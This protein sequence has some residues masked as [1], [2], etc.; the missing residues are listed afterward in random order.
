[1]SFQEWLDARNID[2]ETLT[3]ELLA[4]L[5]SQYERECRRLEPPAEVL[6]QPVDCQSPQR[7]Y[8]ISQ[9]KTLFDMRA[10]YQ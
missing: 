4:A 5:Q 6:I 9:Q 2:C 7:T 3:P 8:R 1:M 10:E